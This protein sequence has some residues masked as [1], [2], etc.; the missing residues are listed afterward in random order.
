MDN[1]KPIYQ[2]PFRNFTLKEFSQWRDVLK[3]LKKNSF[4]NSSFED[5]IQTVY[6]QIAL[7]NYDVALH[8]LET[9]P[10]NN[11]QV[12]F[13]KIL[14]YFGES[15]RCSN[16][17]NNFPIRQS[18][19]LFDEHYR[20]LFDIGIDNYDPATKLIA[21]IEY[22]P[23]TSVEHSADILNKLIR[24]REN[25]LKEN[26]DIF[27]I[28][29]MDFHI[30][31][32]TSTIKNGQGFYIENELLGIQKLFETAKE[33]SEY[34][35][36]K[37]IPQLKKIYDTIN[38]DYSHR[39]SRAVR[40]KILKDKSTRWD[41]IKKLLIKQVSK[42]NWEIIIA[43]LDTVSELDWDNSAVVHP[44][45]EILQKC[46]ER[47]T[48]Q[49]KKPKQKTKQKT[50]EEKL[51]II[52]S[53]SGFV[54]INKFIQIWTEYVNICS[55]AIWKCYSQGF[56]IISRGTDTLPYEYRTLT[57][58]Y[59]KW[60]VESYSDSENREDVVNIWINLMDDIFWCG[61]LVEKPNRAIRVCI[62][63]NLM[64]RNPTMWRPALCVLGINLLDDQPH[65]TQ[66]TFLNDICDEPIRNSKNYYFNVTIEGFMGTLVNNIFQDLV[67][68]NQKSRDVFSDELYEDQF[69]EINVRFSVTNKNCESGKCCFREFI[70]FIFDTN[71]LQKKYLTLLKSHENYKPD[72]VCYLAVESDFNN[73]AI[74]IKN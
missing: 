44:L 11:I 58:I 59:D 51:D 33:G 17:Y 7:T 66:T 39:Q 56:F 69:N 38:V 4:I 24:M 9:C 41:R 62:F 37:L 27:Y 8:F 42:T 2:L 63:L 31:V 15:G 36:L 65:H 26:F 28:R 67:Q 64:R 52:V 61:G 43:I 55:N 30:S 74:V 22:L 45:G 60:P 6:Y 16:H 34:A 57:N 53:C 50:K 46:V 71:N 70:T 5:T 20:E 25:M 32:I 40:L 12:R 1:Y 23:T 10:N 18:T 35:L 19:R 72:G 14:L 68:T 73:R 49:M 3:M 13:L 54:A 29:N 47:C 21:S 48:N